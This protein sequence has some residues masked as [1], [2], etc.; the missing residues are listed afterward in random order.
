MIDLRMKCRAGAPSAVIWRGMT[1]SQK[2]VREYLAK[3]GR[4]G[5]L[6]SR[7]ELTR[8]HAKKMVAIREAERA[9]LRDS[10]C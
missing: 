10:V 6:A 2:H 9:A 7:R 8:S 3:I 4:R 1:E 5:A